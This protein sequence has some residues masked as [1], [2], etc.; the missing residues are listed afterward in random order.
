MSQV[1]IQITEVTAVP[2][3]DACLTRM[4]SSAPGDGRDSPQGEIY[5]QASLSHS[6]ALASH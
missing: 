2:G 1:H 4:L 5:A 3:K 6:P